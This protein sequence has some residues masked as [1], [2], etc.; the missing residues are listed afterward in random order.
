MGKATLWK[1]GG[2][3]CQAF[4]APL[5]ALKSLLKGSVVHQDAK[6]GFPV[7]DILA[8]LGSNLGKHQI[9]NSFIF[10]IFSNLLQVTVPHQ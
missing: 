10:Y 7:K 3:S 9:K 4:P 1:D 5:T 8:D 6:S 2:S